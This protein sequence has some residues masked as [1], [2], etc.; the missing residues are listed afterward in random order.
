MQESVCKKTKHQGP[1]RLQFPS[2]CDKSATPHQ[3]KSNSWL[4]QPKTPLQFQSFST[5]QLLRWTL[6]I[7]QLLRIL[8]VEVLPLPALHLRLLS[9]RNAKLDLGDR[10]EKGV[11]IAKVKGPYLQKRE[12]YKLPHLHFSLAGSLEYILKLGLLNS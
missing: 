3:G 12:I 7:L 10:L 4:G 9:L 1:H 5:L 8:G 6:R 2:L 11:E